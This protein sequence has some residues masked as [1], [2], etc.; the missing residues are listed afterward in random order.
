M[1]GLYAYIDPPNHPNV[2]IYGIHGAF[3]FYSTNF[4]EFN[5]GQRDRLERQERQHKTPAAQP[6]RLEFRLA[7]PQELDLGS[8]K[9]SPAYQGIDHNTCDS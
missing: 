8:A 3:G 9:L 1:Y 5:S 2:G 4:K 7:L 6:A